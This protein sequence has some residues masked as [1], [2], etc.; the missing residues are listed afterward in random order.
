MKLVAYVIIIFFS[1]SQ[2]I[3]AQENTLPSDLETLNKGKS[4]FR[5]NC[6]QCHAVHKKIIG[7]MLSDITEKQS[8]PWLI[9]FIKYPEKVIKSGDEACSKFI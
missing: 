8:I 7:P 6:A 9:N 5:G 3:S 2:L 4:L 1:V